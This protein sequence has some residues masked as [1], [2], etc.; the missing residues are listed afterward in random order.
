VIIPWWFRPLV[1]IDTLFPGLVDWFLQV[2]YVRRFHHPP[3]TDQP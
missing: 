2:V 1:G 3:L